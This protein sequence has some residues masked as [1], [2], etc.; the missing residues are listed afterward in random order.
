MTDMKNPENINIQHVPS[1]FSVKPV[2]YDKNTGEVSYIPEFSNLVFTCRDYEL[3]SSQGINHLRM[4]L[5]QLPAN[6]LRFNP[7]GAALG[8]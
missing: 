1:G 7:G 2:Y 5:N 3:M 8:A 6:P 4:V